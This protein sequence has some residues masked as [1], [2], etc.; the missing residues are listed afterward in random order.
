VL[1]GFYFTFHNASLKE[2]TQN[3]PPEMFPSCFLVIH[4]STTCCQHNKPEI[5][6]HILHT[7]NAYKRSACT[8]STLPITCTNERERDMNNWDEGGK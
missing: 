3:F 7:E 1:R 4:D 8:Y 5:I 6:R 2:E